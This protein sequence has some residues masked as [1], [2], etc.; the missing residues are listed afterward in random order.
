MQYTVREWMMD[1]VVFIE[2]EMTVSDALALMRRRYIQSLIVKKTETSPDY[3][4]LTSTDISDKIVAQG[5]NPVET[6]VKDIMSSPL[7]TVDEGM[8]LRDCAITMKEHRIHHLPV[9]D[10]EGTIVGMISSTD[11]MVAAE[12]MGRA[13][14]ELS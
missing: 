1:L 3:G 11:F 8:S 2:P 5:R 9:V 13:P 12:A 4:I 7:L 14:R 10:G 6:K